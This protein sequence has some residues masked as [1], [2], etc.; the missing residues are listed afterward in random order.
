MNLE[1]AIRDFNTHDMVGSPELSSDYWDCQCDEKY[2]HPNSSDKCSR[3]GAERDEMPDSH[4]NE[5]GEGTHFYSKSLDLL[6]QFKVTVTETLEKTV[7]VKAENQ[8]EA[9]QIVS[10]DW[11]TGMYI[12]G[13][14][15]FTGVEFEA[16]PIEK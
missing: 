10:D 13:A 9:E 5:V 4:Q 11:R 6:R 1:A 12:L 15:N 2:I 16:V 7:T 3:C 14:E 8:I